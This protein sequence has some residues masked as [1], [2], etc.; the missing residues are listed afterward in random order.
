MAALRSAFA[1]LPATLAPFLL[2]AFAPLPP[3]AMWIAMRGSGTHLQ[4]CCCWQPW[5]A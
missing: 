3:P 5:L 2:M 4:R 1:S